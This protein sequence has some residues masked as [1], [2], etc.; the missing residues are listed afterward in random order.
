MRVEREKL[1][2][3]SSELQATNYNQFQ[4]K[5]RNG[6]YQ[7]FSWGWV[8]DYPDPENFLF[9]LTS[10]MSRSRSGGPNT[11]N[12]SNARYDRLFEEMKARE[13]DAQRLA[14]IRKMIAILEVERPWI[15]L[16]YPED[17]ALYH[18]WLH[19]VKPAGLA[20]P[21][22]KYRDLDP[23][24]RERERR[25][26]NQPVTWPAYALLA[27]ALAIVLPGVRTFFRERQ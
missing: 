1:E 6:A 27:A 13:N 5:V 7:I 15:E 12:F 16:Y 26:W 3:L 8:A 11:A 9:L 18:G 20:F 25:A 21:T 17:Y 4:E 24:L 23:I 19:D 14:I 22:A 2:K 10:R